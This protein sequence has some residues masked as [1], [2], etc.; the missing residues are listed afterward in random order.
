MATLLEILGI[1]RARL[2]FFQGDTR[3]NPACPPYSGYGDGRWL[4]DGKIVVTGDGE[5]KT[6]AAKGL[7]IRSQKT[8]SGRICYCRQEK[9]GKRNKEVFVGIIRDE[10]YNTD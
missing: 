9:G 5:E 4:A 3:A 2:G 10:R 7:K 6:I 1:K 8:G